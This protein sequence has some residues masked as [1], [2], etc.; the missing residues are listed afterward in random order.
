MKLFTGVRFSKSWLLVMGLLYPLISVAGDSSSLTRSSVSVT[1]TSGAPTSAQVTF[2]TANAMYIPGGPQGGWTSHCG[3][4]TT[5]SAAITKMSSTIGLPTTG[6]IPLFQQGC[7]GWTAFSITGS[8]SGVTSV[9]GNTTGQTMQIDKNIVV[10]GGTTET[11]TVSKA[12][13]LNGWGVN[14]CSAKFT[15][16]TAPTAQSANNNYYIDCCPGTAASHNTTWQLK[17]SQSGAGN[18]A[19]GGYAVISNTPVFCP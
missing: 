17:P 11:L 18:P 6:Y 19:P 12:Y 9:G 13:T 16:P 2:T 14:T 4:N 1:S 15:L 8:S 5:I 10:T 7:N 3:Q